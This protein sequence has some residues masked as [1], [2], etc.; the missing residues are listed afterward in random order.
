MKHSFSAYTNGCRCDICKAANA[1]VQREYRKNNPVKFKQ[2][3]DA[4]VKKGICTKCRKRPAASPS[5]TCS[6]C[7]LQSRNYQA[8]KAER[9]EITMAQYLK[10]RG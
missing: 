9:P 1:R 8:R 5:R 3:Y 10:A 7:N 6:N 2:A 4:L